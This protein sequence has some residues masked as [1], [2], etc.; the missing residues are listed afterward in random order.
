MIIIIKRISSYTTHPSEGITK[1]YSRKYFFCYSSIDWQH[2][3]IVKKSSTGFLGSW[4]WTE[5]TRWNPG[6]RLLEEDVTIK[7]EGNSL[8]KALHTPVQ[9]S[10]SSCVLCTAKPH[11][12]ASVGTGPD[13]LLSKVFKGKKK[14]RKKKVREKLTFWSQIF[15]V[16]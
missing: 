6:R 3:E 8:V 5:I 11:I 2:G 16:C 9:Q 10:S 14:E 1:Q 15:W 13:L 12:K 7:L 4:R